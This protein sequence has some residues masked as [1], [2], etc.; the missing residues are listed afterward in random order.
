MALNFEGLTDNDL[1]T[2][3]DDECE[4]INY[5]LVA[6]R[7]LTGDNSHLGYVMAH[8]SIKEEYVVWLINFQMGGLHHGNYFNY[9]YK[10]KSEAHKQAWN[11]FN[12]RG[13]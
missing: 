3:A 2:I 10:E 13:N 6:M 11:N 12:E 9:W 1:L 7:R 5:R 4:R 8:S